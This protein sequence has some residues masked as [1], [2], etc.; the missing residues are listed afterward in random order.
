MKYLI[1]NPISPKGGNTG[2]P[3]YTS[4]GPWPCGCDGNN[5]VCVTPTGSKVHIM[6]LPNPNK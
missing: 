6:S 4:Y 3:N 2:C 1:L 5:P